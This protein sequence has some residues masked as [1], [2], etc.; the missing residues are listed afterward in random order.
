MAIDMNK[1]TPN[2]MDGSRLAITEEK[3]LIWPIYISIKKL[4]TEDLNEVILYLHRVKW[5]IKK[6]K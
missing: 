4:K 3:L 6:D 5:K 1:D 2:S